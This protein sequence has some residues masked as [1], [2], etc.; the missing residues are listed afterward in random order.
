VNHTGIKTA[1][2]HKITA[3]KIVVATNG[4]IIDKISKIYD[5]QAPVRT[6]VIAARFKKGAIP[7]AL[8]W[9]TG[10]M[11]SK[12]MIP[13]Y[14]YVRIQELEDDSE[15]DLLVVGGEDHP[16]GAFNHMQR[17]YLTL[18]RWARKRFPIEDIV[19]RWSGQVLEPKDSMAF[20]GRNPRDK[21]KNIFIATGDS[22]NGMTHGTIA[23]MLLSDLILGKKNKWAKLYN[24]SRK[25]KN[26]RKKSSG[27]GSTTKPKK[28]SMEDAMKK[29]GALEPREGIVIEIRGKKKDPMAF[30]RDE[31]G[32]LHSF[33]AL[34]T[35]LGCTIQWNNSEKSFDCPCHGSRFSYSGLVING[36]ANDN[37]ERAN[38]SS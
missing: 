34:C 3:R 19:Y 8:Y 15:Y 13:P 20:I 32:K 33:S 1:D 21:R 38:S 25:I 11:E 29:A 22:G 27:G 16:T 14:H 9:D 35:H 7:K 10:N 37:L 12:N 26:R 24:S 31:T 5:K 18:E 4:L 2:G 23:G 28:V 30:Y 17:R 36:P 6:Y